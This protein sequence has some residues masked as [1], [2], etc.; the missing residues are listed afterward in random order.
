MIS[1]LSKLSEHLACVAL[2][3]LPFTDAVPVQQKALER[4]G[5]VAAQNLTS[6][7]E[8]LAYLQ[9]LR[10]FPRRYV[11]A[12]CGSWSLVL[13]DMLGECCHVDVLFHSRSTGCR[14]VSGIAVSAERRFSFLERG[15]VIRDIH[16]FR[17]NRWEM[18]S[19]GT[20]LSF[21]RGSPYTRLSESSVS[22]YLTLVTGVVF[23]L[24]PTSSFG[25]IVGLE[26]SWREVRAQPKEFRIIDDLQREKE[27]NKRIT[28]NSV[29]SP[30]RV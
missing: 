8:A 17:E 11:V 30:L 3:E 7:R 26:R 25:R 12:E 15:A 16:C 19:E 20:P 28:D 21:E 10:S 6:W 5:P 22:D 23:P 9:P 14:A 4:F 18:R 24:S 1:S 29:A 13:C 2:A 27:P